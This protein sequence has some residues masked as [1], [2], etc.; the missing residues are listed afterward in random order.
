MKNILKL[1][2]LLV[3]VL[4][5]SN[6]SVA[7]EKTEEFKPN[8]KLYGQFF[9]DYF[10]V[11]SADTGV[12]NQPNTISKKGKNYNG[13]RFRRT[14]LGY[15]YFF[16][17]KISAK[18]CLDADEA[19]VTTDLRPAFFVKDALLKWN[20][21]KGQDLIFGIQPTP[22]FA[23]SEGVWA[24]RFI[25]KTITDLRKFG[26]SRDFGISLKGKVDKKGL[27]NYWL[28][29]SNGSEGKPELDKYKKYY[30]QINLKP[31]PEIDIALFG[32][33]AANKREVSPYTKFYVSKNDITTG[34]FI[35]YSKKDKFG[36]G[37]ESFFR[38]SL[39][40]FNNGENLQDK[41]CIGIS[42]F[43][44][45]NIVQ[46][47]GVFARYDYV[48]FNTSNRVHA[49]VRQLGLAGLTYKPIAAFVISPNI[50]YE[51][52]EKTQAVGIVPAQKIDA[53]FIPRITLCWII[54]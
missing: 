26:C 3:I 27:F 9:F 41:E 6:T 49:D 11:V 5:L 19:A 24:H 29:L 52:Y 46:K 32:E 44:H 47:I 38:K 28:M 50:M 54:K 20:F 48:D 18:V 2:V 14:Q 45:Y 25:E 43:A 13:F 30:A 42:A 33:V 31:K 10:Y 51:M 23:A 34:V 7:Q 35:G 16:A 21:F 40:G 8:G 17:P 39:N 36:V 15:E 53:T 12:A 1:A 4:Q 22:T 37:V